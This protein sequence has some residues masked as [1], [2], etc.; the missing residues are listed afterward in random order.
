MGGV[1]GGTGNG[2]I[3]SLLSYN[4]ELYGVMEAAWL[5]IRGKRGA[6]DLTVMKLEY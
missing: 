2:L 6:I 5:V 4:K 3:K 1:P